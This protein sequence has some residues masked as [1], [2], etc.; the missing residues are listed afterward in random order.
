MKELQSSCRSRPGL[1]LGRAVG[2]QVG[3]WP[4]K[5]QCSHS[6]VTKEVGCL[7]WKARLPGLREVMLSVLEGNFPV[8]LLKQQCQ[9]EYKATHK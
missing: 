6:T 9:Q 8:S 1:G 7:G 5:D 2:K 3:G 4:F